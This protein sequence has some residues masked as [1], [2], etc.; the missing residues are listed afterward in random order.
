ME[1]LLLVIGLVVGTV[2]GA[3]GAWFLAQLSLYLHSYVA[4]PSEGARG[5][6]M[7]LMRQYEEQVRAGAV[8]PPRLP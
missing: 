5:S 6:L 7:E 4:R 1:I 2:L 3:L 8:V